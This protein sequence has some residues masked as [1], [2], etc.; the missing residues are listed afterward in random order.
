MARQLEGVFALLARLLLVPGAMAALSIGVAA[1]FRE[2]HAALAFLGV[3]M[4][5][6]LAA[7]GC[8]WAARGDRGGD[9]KAPGPMIAVALAWLA[10]SLLGALP[11]WFI[12]RS[13]SALPEAVSL[14]QAPLNAWFESMSGFTSTGLTMTSNPAELP[15]SLQWWRTLSEWV[16]G[17]GV[18]M[19]ALAVIQPGDDSFSRVHQAEA[20][21]KVMGDT[22]TGSARRLWKIYA[23]FTLASVI[24][25]LVAGMDWWEALNHGMTGF[26][27][28]GFTITSDSYRSYGL[29]IKTVTSVI[30]LLGAVSMPMYYGLLVERRLGDDVR[31]HQ[32]KA[33]AIVLSVGL[34][35]LALFTRATRFDASLM[36]LVFQWASAF[37]TCGFAS[38]ELDSWPGS[39][40]GLLT[41]GMFVG[42]MAGSTTGGLKLNRLSWLAQGA[43]WR[44]KA[45]ALPDVAAQSELLE[46]NQSDERLRRMGHA[47]TLAVLWCL[48]WG[49]G[50]LLLAIEVDDQYEFHQVVFDAAS[51]LGSVGLSTG[52]IS[53]SLTGV[54]KVTAIMLMWLGRLEVIGVLVLFAAL[55][56]AARSERQDSVPPRP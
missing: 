19:T 39:A 5:S 40:L 54:G 10:A 32:A 9:L 17:A 6:A 8:R 12:A 52:V 49:T 14:F 27:T 31:W 26:A 22:A 29:P 3:V 53:E 48:V 20:R 47:A 2:W 50:S 38:V 13:A 55:F 21:S 4:L 44:L 43:W 7:I 16:G 24:A 11:F 33:F 25:L 1:A 51:A 18:V 45:A 28:G 15:P 46:G 37:G 34:A 42:G 23:G 36:D 56:P 30:M 35:A 41:A